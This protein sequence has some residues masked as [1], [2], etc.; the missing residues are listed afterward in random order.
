MTQPA[1]PDPSPAPAS[2]GTP[3]TA[4][5]TAPATLRDTVPARCAAIIVAAGRGTRMGGG[6]PKQWQPLC[7]KPVLAH[8][9]AAFRAAGAAPIV[10]VLHP[11]D[12]ARAAFLMDEGVELASGGAT[13]SA[14]VRNALD[15]LSGRGIERVLIHD[16][17]RPLVRPALIAR[18]AAALDTSPAAAPALPVTDAL[19]LG[20]EG[21][22]ETTVPRD[23]LFRAQTPQGFRF[24]AI[25]AAHRDGGADA[26]DDVEVALAA[27]LDVAILEGDEDNIKLT[28]PGDFDR[29]ARILGA[30]TM[31]IRT[32]TGF[33]VHRF[34]PGDAV[35]L[36]GVRV[37]FARGLD[38][39][40]DADVGMHALTDAIYGALAEGDIGRHFPP[41][42]PKWKGADSRIFLR[43]AAA[44]VQARGFRITS[45][46]VTLI[47]EQPKIG[48][49][50]DAMRAALSGIMGIET[51]R[52][53]VK[54]TTSER[55]GFTGREEGIAALAGV[56]LVS[57]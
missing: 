25:L 20:A 27:G 9:L 45:A 12:M 26:A 17:A 7:G 14:S 16:G 40:S 37:P 23:G 21:H 19:W 31:D 33:D 8:T 42:D 5:D 41:S 29:A 15:A 34:G 32:G 44:R 11:D 6:L 35:V 30:Q 18:V 57:G 10:L 4:P 36:C 43:H 47:C 1:P 54:A 38:G 46:D 2:G 24:D 53:S 52:V 56:T 50:A 13:R 39:H 49:H 55:L 28:W 3:D 51:D 48:P 22:V